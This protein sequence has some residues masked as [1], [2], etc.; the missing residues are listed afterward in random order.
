MVADVQQESQRQAWLRYLIRADVRLA[1]V[2]HCLRQAAGLE[3]TD[4]G[5]RHLEA[6]AGQCDGLRLELDVR[7]GR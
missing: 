2:A 7:R 1:E 4:A 5:A 6:V 3:A